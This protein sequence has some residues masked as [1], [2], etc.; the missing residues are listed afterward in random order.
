M[1]G[2]VPEKDPEEGQESNLLPRKYK[3]DH[4][5]AACTLYIKKDKN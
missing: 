3:M 4:A 1:S 5:C 2:T